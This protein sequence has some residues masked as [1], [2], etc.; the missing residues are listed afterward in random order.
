MAPKDKRN[1]HL[2]NQVLVTFGGQSEGYNDLMK[3]LKANNDKTIKTFDIVSK[4]LKLF[5]GHLKFI[6]ATKQI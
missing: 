2:H 3:I 4:V 1:S 6:E 5:K